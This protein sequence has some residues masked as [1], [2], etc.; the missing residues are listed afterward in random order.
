MQIES[1]EFATMETIITLFFVVLFVVI[2]LYTGTF[3]NE[4][5]PQ[6]YA[7][8]KATEIKIILEH[9]KKA[10]VIDC[11]EKLFAFYPIL[12]SDYNELQNFKDN[13]EAAFKQVTYIAAT[14]YSKIHGENLTNYQSNLLSLNYPFR[15]LY[16]LLVIDALLRHINKMMIEIGRLKTETAKKKRFLR[17]SESCN[18]AYN[19]LMERGDESLAQKVKDV[20]K[21]TCYGN[22][23]ENFNVDDSIHKL[24]EKIDSQN[25]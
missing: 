7:P 24:T 5:Y 4:A 10:E 3:K 13:N 22:E 1:V 2:G 12:L 18:M 17:I 8:K 15:N 16:S 20:I 6:K 23:Q 19:E 11:L 14:R 25:N 21:Q 9:Y